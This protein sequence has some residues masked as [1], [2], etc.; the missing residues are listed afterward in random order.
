MSRKKKKAPAKTKPTRPKRDLPAE[1]LPLETSVSAEKP[2]PIEGISPT[3]ETLPTNEADLSSAVASINASQLTGDK[4][5]Q[6]AAVSLPDTPLNLRKAKIITERYPGP[7][8]FIPGESE[9]FFG[10][11]ADAEEL[12]NRI[13][14]S[15]LTV[16]E[17][18][19]GLGKTSLLN[20][21]VFTRLEEEGF[22]ILKCRVSES[23]RSKST[24]EF[25]TQT[26]VNDCKNY[27]FVE[28]NGRQFRQNFFAANIRL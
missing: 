21:K 6:I 5:H 22:V 9:I 24:T 17:G 1:H 19:S 4:S 28:G 15:R 20:T 13:F 8:A 27:K 14:V 25:L 23:L 18:R 11:D 16:L 3:E 12:F 2:E 10:R 26:F 7:R